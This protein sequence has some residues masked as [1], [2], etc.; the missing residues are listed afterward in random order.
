MNDVNSVRRTFDIDILSNHFDEI[1][2][3]NL[4][5]KIVELVLFQFKLVQFVDT[6]PRH[7]QLQI[8]GICTNCQHTHNSNYFVVARIGL[9]RHSMLCGCVP[10][11]IAR[12]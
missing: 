10:T 11:L 4:K 9:R 2:E 3:K 7:P 5:C 6:L 12:D 1:F 8:V